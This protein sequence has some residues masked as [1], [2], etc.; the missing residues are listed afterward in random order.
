M[1]SSV[2]R[3]VR[4]GTMSGSSMATPHVAGVAALWAETSPNLRGVN[5][6]RKLQATAKPLP[7]PASKV[8]A[9]LVQSP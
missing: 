3:P 2:P 8:G 9:G 1:F 5:L 7:F 6:W 4:Y